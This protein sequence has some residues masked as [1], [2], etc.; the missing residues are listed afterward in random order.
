M[1]NEH[2][3]SPRI[4][5]SIPVTLRGMDE[6]GKP[7]EAA[8]RTITLNLHGARLQVGRRLKPG[9]TVRLLNQVNST[10][11][12]FRVVGP[13]APP[14]DHLGE[15]G[16]ECLHVDKN[17]WDIHFPDTDADLDAHVLLSCRNCQSISLQSLSLVEVEV[18]ETAGLLT[19]PCV[20]CGE[21]TAWGY[22]QRSFELETK[23]YQA[24]V[25]EA[26]Q[27]SP[28][29][30]AERRRTVR[31]QAQI[32]VRVRDYFGDTEIASTENI[33]MD[34]LCF[35]SSR[36]Y[37]MGQGVVVICPYEPGIEKPEV[38]A[39][40]VRMEPALPGSRYVYGIR[41]EPVGYHPPSLGG[42]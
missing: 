25:S 39:R 31:R 42:Y 2:R 26:A 1:E 10:E 41:Y 3:R 21:S 16:L 29:L 37:L 23:A 13:I 15:W 7:F 5:F 33:S 12:E 19:K 4:M 34:G 17:I 24:A 18:L 27:G 9:Q 32:P 38:R 30:A 35:T 14:V 40:I 6:N 22:P 20:Q 36:T 28:R 11:A 8:A